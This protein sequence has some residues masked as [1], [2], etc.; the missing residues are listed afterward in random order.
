MATKAEV[1][2][3]DG[4]CPKNQLVLNTRKVV[5]FSGVEVSEKLFFNES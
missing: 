3:H 4:K 5:S 2:Q 1:F